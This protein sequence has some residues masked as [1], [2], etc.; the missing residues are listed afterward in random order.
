MGNNEA[1]LACVGKFAATLTTTDKILQMSVQRESA[2]VAIFSRRCSYVSM[3]L[4]GLL[5]DAMG[6]AP[7]EEN[8]T[9]YVTIRHSNLQSLPC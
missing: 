4:L 7:A 5:Y 8:D 6:R 1:I 3:H 2:M 9:C